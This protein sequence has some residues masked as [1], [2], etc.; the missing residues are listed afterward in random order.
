MRALSLCVVTG[1]CLFLSGCQ[2]FPLF[3]NRMADES[4][5]GDWGRDVDKPWQARA[6]RDRRSDSNRRGQPR[7][8]PTQLANLNSF[9]QT[10]TAALQKNSL[11]DS[12]FT[13]RLKKITF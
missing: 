2:G 1:F 8:D 13:D 3:N 12:Y 9:L 5:M 11:A 7:L 6:E 10:G 4:S